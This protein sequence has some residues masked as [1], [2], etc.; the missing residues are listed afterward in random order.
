ML[1]H[2]L[3]GPKPIHSGSSGADYF[4]R[5]NPAGLRLRVTKSLEGRGF[6]VIREPLPQVA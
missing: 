4:D 5:L 1:E 6:K 2:R 3:S